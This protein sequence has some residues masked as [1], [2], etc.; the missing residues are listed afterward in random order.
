[1]LMAYVQKSITFSTTDSM[2]EK[3]HW[4]NNSPRNPVIFSDD[5]WG[6][7]SPPQHSI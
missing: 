7:Q 1:M 2:S 3:Y 5:D 4:F 6:V